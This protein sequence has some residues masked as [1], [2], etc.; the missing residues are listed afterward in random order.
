MPR[1]SGVP[2]IGWG[3][4]SVLRWRACGTHG[5]APTTQP[6][7]PAPLSPPLCALL[8]AGQATFSLSAAFRKHSNASGGP[9]ASTSLNYCLKAL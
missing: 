8:R 6:L 2:T 1:N 9:L 3:G 7:S 4:A 5:V